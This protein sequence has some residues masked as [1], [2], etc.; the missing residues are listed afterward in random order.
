MS[1]CSSRFS[2]LAASPT[3]SARL[4][5]LQHGW[6][7]NRVQFSVPALRGRIF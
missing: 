6:A 5:E 7:H 1:L 2:A 3:K 4:S